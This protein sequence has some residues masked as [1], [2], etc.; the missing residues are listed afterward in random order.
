VHDPALTAT[1][2]ALPGA[3]FMVDGAAPARNSV[4]A[5][6]GA[7]LKVTPALALAA[8]FDGELARNAQSY[9]GTASLR[10]AW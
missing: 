1:F 9:A 7:E 3:S 5:S 6:A 10:Y 4:L 8:Q 2:H